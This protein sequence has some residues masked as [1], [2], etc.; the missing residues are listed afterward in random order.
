MNIPAARHTD[1]QAEKTDKK[2][3]V[4]GLGALRLCSGLT[5]RDESERDRDRDID[6]E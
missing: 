1:K 5:M 3:E 2:R 4:V 6:R